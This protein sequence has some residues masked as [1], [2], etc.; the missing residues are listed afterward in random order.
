[1]EGGPGT[2]LFLAGP[3]NDVMRAW[4]G[5]RDVVNGGPG[6]DRAWLDRGLDRAI[7]VE[8]R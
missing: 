2:D 3:G 8:L 7:S 6:R 5:R 1:M 4:D